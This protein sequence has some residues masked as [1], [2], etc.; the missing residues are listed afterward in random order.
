LLQAHVLPVNSEFFVRLYDRGDARHAG[1]TFT[2]NVIAKIPNHPSPSC[3]V[4]T[5]IFSKTQKVYPY[6]SLSLASELSS[7]NNKILALLT[8]IG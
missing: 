3:S 5:W 2:W 4:T 7:H 1:S 8:L 6:I